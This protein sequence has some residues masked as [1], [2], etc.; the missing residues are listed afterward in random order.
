MDWSFP[1]DDS[2]AAGDITTRGFDCWGCRT[3]WSFHSHFAN[4]SQC[5]QCKLKMPCYHHLINNMIFTLFLNNEGKIELKQACRQLVLISMHLILKF[6][7]FPFQI[8]LLLHGFYG[9]YWK[10]FPLYSSQCII[11]GMYWIFCSILPFF[12]CITQGGEPTK[13]P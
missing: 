10:D 12:S 6:Q 8:V 2:G 5:F 4:N 7:M 3:R 11:P 13:Q 9:M 1:V